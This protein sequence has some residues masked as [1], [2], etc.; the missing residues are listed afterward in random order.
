[1]L[2]SSRTEGLSRKGIGPRLL[3]VLPASRGLTAG[4][5]VLSLRMPIAHAVME[6]AIGTSAVGAPSMPRR[7]DRP[8]G[9]DRLPQPRGDATAATLEAQDAHRLLD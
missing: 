5:V 1:M 9:R 4:K 2:P 3:V 6:A 8:R 7:A